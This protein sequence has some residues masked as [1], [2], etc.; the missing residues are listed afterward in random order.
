MSVRFNPRRRIC[1]LY[2][3]D[4][5]YDLEPTRFSDF[6]RDYEKELDSHKN[7]IPVDTEGKEDEFKG[8]GG[9]IPP[10]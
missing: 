4:V 2:S 8:L 10:L 9:P 7:S 5:P 6:L 1:D 3:F